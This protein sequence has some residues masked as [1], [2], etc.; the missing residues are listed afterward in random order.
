M[1]DLETRL[2]ALER[3]GAIVDIMALEGEYCR[4]WD[5]GTGEEWAAVFTP[6]GVFEMAKTRNVPPVPSVDEFAV[7]GHEALAAYHT[8]L[9]KNWVVLHQMHLPAIK[10][11]GDTAHAVVFFECPVLAADGGLALMSRE[12]GVYEVDY[13]RTPDGWKMARRI[14]HAV[15]RDG[16]SHFGRPDFRN[17]PKPA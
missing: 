16:A 10:V 2:Q 9:K 14:E 5:F 3:Q 12:I 17:R 1:S 11:D 15:F 4:A 13:V 7:V 8:L 6:D